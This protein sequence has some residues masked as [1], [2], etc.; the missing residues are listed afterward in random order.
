[1]AYDYTEECDQCGAKDDVVIYGKGLEYKGVG[2][3]PGPRC[4][5]CMR[6]LK[7]AIDFMRTVDGDDVSIRLVECV[8]CGEPLPTSSD[9]ADIGRPMCDGC[10]FA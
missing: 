8:S 4:H 3:P 2:L 1:M 5:A 10:F 7:K 9:A 6:R